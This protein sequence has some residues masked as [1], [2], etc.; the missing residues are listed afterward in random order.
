MVG[1]VNFGSAIAGGALKTDFPNF[2]ISRW[3]ASSSL[4]ATVSGASVMA[5]RLIIVGFGLRGL[6][7]ILANW[8]FAIEIDVET[9]QA[10]G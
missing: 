6:R 1:D 7:P 3:L 5:G 4:N 9:N 10:A 8:R 2:G